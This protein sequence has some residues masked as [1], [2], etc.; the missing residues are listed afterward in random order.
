MRLNNITEGKGEDLFANGQSSRGFLPLVKVPEPRDHTAHYVL[1]ASNENSSTAT[2]SIISC[3]SGMG[4][5]G[6]P[7]PAGGY[8]L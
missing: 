4:V 1:L 3:D 5:R 6:F 8:D 2:G 7:R